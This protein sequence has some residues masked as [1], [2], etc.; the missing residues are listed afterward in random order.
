MQRY[1]KHFIWYPILKLLSCMVQPHRSMTLLLTLMLN[2]AVR[3]L[4]VH[5]RR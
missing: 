3:R 4:Q 5:E 2:M 1:L